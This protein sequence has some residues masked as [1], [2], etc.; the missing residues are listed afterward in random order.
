[1]IGRLGSKTLDSLS[2]QNNSLVESEEKMNNEK[3]KDTSQHKSVDVTCVK[4]NFHKAI[5]PCH[6]CKRRFRRNSNLRK[7]IQVKHNSKPSSCSLVKVIAFNSDEECSDRQMTRE[8]NTSEAPLLLHHSVNAPTKNVF[9]ATETNLQS[10]PA[11]SQNIDDATSTSLQTQLRNECQPFP[12]DSANQSGSHKQSTSKSSDQIQPLDLRTKKLTNDKLSHGIA[13]IIKSETGPKIVSNPYF[14]PGL[15]AYTQV[16]LLCHNSDS[17]L[18]FPSTLEMQSPFSV[19]FCRCDPF[20]TQ[21]HRAYGTTTE[22]LSGV[23]GN[24]IQNQKRE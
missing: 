22:N 24:F 5:F 15:L 9:S 1:M 8:S 2:S 7:H 17:R 11:Y 23:S 14:Q 6:L 20:L 18:S 12:R 13:E 4:Q 16:P 10:L 3:N 21:I 19:P